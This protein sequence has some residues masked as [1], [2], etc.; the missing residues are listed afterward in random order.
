MV[1]S[2]LEARP[3]LLPPFLQALNKS[4]LSKEQKSGAVGV[5]QVDI[6]RQYHV[7]H[8]YSH[9][10]ILTNVNDF[11]FH[12]TIFLCLSELASTNRLPSVPITPAAPLPTPRRLQSSHNGGEGWRALGRGPP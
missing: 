5:I 9:S 12:S 4:H 10:Q 6:L 8:C 3:D 7:S 2:E 1:E 11:P